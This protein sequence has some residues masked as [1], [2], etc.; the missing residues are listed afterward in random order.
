MKNHYLINI[1]YGNEKIITNLKFPLLE[2]KI[3]LRGSNGSGK[4]SV[5]NF[6]YESRKKSVFYVTQS[7][8]LF[9]NF[10]IKDNIVI[11]GKGLIS[12]QDVNDFLLKFNIIL[13]QGKKIKELSGGEVHL[14]YIAIAFAS[15]KDTIFIDEPEN[16][17]DQENISLLFDIINETTKNIL[18]VSHFEM[19][20]KN[21][22]EVDLDEVLYYE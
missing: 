18:L 14:L 21:Y 8:K 13:E 1:S 2:G 9:L 20:K 6:L 11:I 7:P 19:N 16:N 17:L 5:L 3:L 22:L 12:M 4:S 10:S 15:E